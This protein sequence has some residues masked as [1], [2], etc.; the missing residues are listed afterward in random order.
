MVIT[1]AIITRAG[2]GLVAEGL[3]K[4]NEQKVSTERQMGGRKI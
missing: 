3:R 1:V 2:I 4:S